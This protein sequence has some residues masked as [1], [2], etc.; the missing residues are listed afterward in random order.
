MAPTLRTAGSGD[1][2]RGS[3]LH[4]AACG[5]LHRSAARAPPVAVHVRGFFDNEQVWRDVVEVNGVLKSGHI[6]KGAGPSPG[7]LE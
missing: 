4:R 1:C 2:P 6:A 5:V 3:R 7:A